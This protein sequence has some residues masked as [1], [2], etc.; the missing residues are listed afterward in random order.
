MAEVATW[1]RP[2]GLFHRIHEI[3]LPGDAEES[4]WRTGAY[5]LRRRYG[6]GELV[7][8]DDLWDVEQEDSIIR[9][10][11]HASSVTSERARRSNTL[12]ANRLQVARF[13]GSATAQPERSA[14]NINIWLLSRR[15][16]CNFGVA[17]ILE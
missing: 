13:L 9:V 11:A 12:V 7:W 2:G 15:R 16:G 17:L 14:G 8:D 3:R 1:L 10:P 4:E 5:P 6:D